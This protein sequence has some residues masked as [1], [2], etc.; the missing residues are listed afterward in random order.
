M[1]KIEL[2]SLVFLSPAQAA[3][4]FHRALLTREHYKDAPYRRSVASE[5]LAFLSD[6]QNPA[7]RDAMVTTI[8]AEVTTSAEDMILAHERARRPRLA[9]Q[10]PEGVSGTGAIT[11]VKLDRCNSTG[12]L[13][14]R[15]TLSLSRSL[16]MEPY[17]DGIHLEDGGEV[18]LAWAPEDAGKLQPVV[19]RLKVDPFAG[20][21]RLEVCWEPKSRMAQAEDRSK[22]SYDLLQVYPA[23]EDE[24]VFLSPP[25]YEEEVTPVFTTLDALVEDEALATV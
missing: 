10:V 13:S 1:D 11:G 16:R 23:W 4:E 24:S 19:S 9:I 21:Y 20:E 18:R 12:I 2:L 15:V 17:E 3:I 5:R 8:R 25:D 22:R 14:Y 7:I 6:L